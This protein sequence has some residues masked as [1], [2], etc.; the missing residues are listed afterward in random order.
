MEYGES[1][2][3]RPKNTK[4]MAFDNPPGARETLSGL[5]F[6]SR[7]VVV[8]YSMMQTHHGINNAMTAFFNGPGSVGARESVSRYTRSVSRAAAKSSHMITVTTPSDA[9]ANSV[10]SRITNALVPSYG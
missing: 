7:P 8:N 4:Y 1:V 5:T 9:Y 6:S 2:M 3:I 10:A